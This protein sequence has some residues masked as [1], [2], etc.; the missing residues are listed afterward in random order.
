MNEVKAT[1]TYRNGICQRVTVK[2]EDGKIVA[3]WA[4][5]RWYTVRTS[6]GIATSKIGGQRQNI[7][8]A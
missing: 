7:V 2:V 5:N 1:I 3:V 4:Q 6:K 8:I